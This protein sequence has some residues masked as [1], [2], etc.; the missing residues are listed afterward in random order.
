MRINDDIR[1]ALRLVMVTS[2]CAI[3][4]YFWYVILY[5]FMGGNCL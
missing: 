5:A 3:A 2:L 4:L 1:Y